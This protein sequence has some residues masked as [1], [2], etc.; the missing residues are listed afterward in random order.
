MAVEFPE[1]HEDKEQTVPRGWYVWTHQHSFKIWCHI[2]LVI[3]PTRDE[4]TTE[5]AWDFD[6]KMPSN[7]SVFGKDDIESIFLK[8]VNFRTSEL[9]WFEPDDYW[10][11]LV[12]RPKEYMRRMGYTP[13]PIEDCL[14]LIA[15]AVAEA[16]QKVKQYV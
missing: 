9:W 7:L 10:W 11:P 3:H 2:L 4:F 6:G 14:L 13:D 15:P 5:A 8:S 16:G 12:L 1:Y